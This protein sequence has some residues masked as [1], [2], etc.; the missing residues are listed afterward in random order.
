LK[1]VTVPSSER[2]DGYRTSSPAH[3]G[4]QNDARRELAV[5]V[6]DRRRCADRGSLRQH[7]GCSRQAGQLMRIQAPTARRPTVIPGAPSGVG[8]LATC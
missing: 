8:R 6:K 1:M 4:A 3:I 7:A 5:A 2:I